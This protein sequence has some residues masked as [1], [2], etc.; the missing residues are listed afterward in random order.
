MKN[1]LVL[2]LFI[3]TVVGCVASPITVQV[4]NDVS[5]NVEQDI[6]DST[7]TTVTNPPQSSYQPEA[8][9]GRWIWG[10][11]FLLVIFLGIAY[12]M[13]RGIESAVTKEEYYD[14]WKP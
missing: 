4:A 8:E 5:G 12:V 7:T 11:L 13:N 14:Q 9:N 6:G 2:I 10:G 3:F 1:F